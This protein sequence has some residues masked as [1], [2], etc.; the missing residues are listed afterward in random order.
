MTD[1]AEE[2]PSEFE[3]EARAILTDEQLQAELEDAVWWMDRYLEHLG[4]L[5]GEWDVLDKLEFKQTRRTFLEF[6]H[7]ASDLTGLWYMRDDHERR[8]TFVREIVKRREDRLR[9]EAE[10]Q[11]D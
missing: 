5:D 6:L 2:A 10:R 11:D 7:Y 1:G 8:A 3:L 4:P 9:M